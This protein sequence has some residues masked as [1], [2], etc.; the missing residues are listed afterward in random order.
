[1]CG[2]RA[3]G[4]TPLGAH[5]Q[6][7]T[8]RDSQLCIENSFRA[9]VSCSFGCETR[10]SRGPTIYLLKKNPHINEPMQFKAVLLK[11][12]LY[13]DLK[14]KKIRTKVKRSLGSITGQEKS[15]KGIIRSRNSNPMHANTEREGMTSALESQGFSDTWSLLFPSSITHGYSNC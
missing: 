15:V 13:K 10:G 6:L 8:S 3:A 1:M 5:S 2:P 7:S 4:W 11:I 12:H 14:K 9:M